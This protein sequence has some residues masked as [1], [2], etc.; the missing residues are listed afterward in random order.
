MTL[1]SADTKASREA[2]PGGGALRKA[3]ADTGHLSPCRCRT[4]GGPGIRHPSGQAAWGGP[5]LGWRR[6]R[7]SGAWCRTG[8]TRLHSP[9][10]GSRR[11]GIR[12]RGWA[13]GQAVV[14]GGHDSVPSAQPRRPPPA[15]A[16]PRLGDEA[17]RRR[18]RIHA[19]ARQVVRLIVHVRL[20]VR[21]TLMTP[22]PA[23]RVGTQ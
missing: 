4:A 18:G 16:G 17:G 11:G 20:W 15:L 9:L 14:E 13:E 5:G 8:T 1:N 10:C 2:D 12:P 23:G 7:G 21:L 22:S 6:G 3:G 19:G